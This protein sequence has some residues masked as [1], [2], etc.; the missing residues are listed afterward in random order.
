MGALRPGA[1]PFSMSALAAGW[2]RCAAPP[3]ASPS[4]CCDWPRSCARSFRPCTACATCCAPR[5]CCPP[6]PKRPQRS[7]A[8]PSGRRSQCTSTSGRCTTHQLRFTFAEPFQRFLMLPDFLGEFRPQLERYKLDYL[9]LVATPAPAGTQLSLTQSKLLGHSYLPVGTPYPHDE[10][11]QPMILL[12]QVNFAEAPAL[13]PYPTAGILQLF[14][15]P[16]EWVEMDDYCVLFHPDSAAE[17]Q[18]YFSFLTPDLYANSPINVEHTLSFS[19]AT[20][21]GGAEDCRFQPDLGGK[22]YYKYLRT[23]PEE[24]REE[25]DQYCCNAGHKIGGYAYFAQRDPRAATASRAND[26]QLLQLDSDEEISFGDSGLAHLF[27]NPT[28]L[29]ERRFDQAYFYWDCC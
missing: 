16:T 6:H 3:P 29:Q 15:S 5:A 8:A 24:Q 10:L 9:K 7:R 4:P 2:S 20:E 19:L 17:A 28:A 21:Y 14:V 27:I 1:G 18:T 12:A 26:V 23:L 13:P 22:S 11:G 25:L